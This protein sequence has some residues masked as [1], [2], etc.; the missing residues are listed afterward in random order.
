MNKNQI[1]DMIESNEFQTIYQPIVNIQ[2]NHVFGYE[3]LTRVHNVPIGDF[4]KECEKN[5]LTSQFELR[6]L[7]NGIE[8][9][10]WRESTRLFLNISYDT[11]I[12]H[13]QE[14]EELLK[15]SGEITFEFLETSVIDECQL[16][17]LHVKMTSLKR[18]FGTQFAIDDYGSGYADI[19]RVL[20]HPT[21]FVKTDAE[22]LKDVQNHHGKK[23]VLTNLHH[24]LEKKKKK[25][26]VEGVE[27]KEQFHY[28]V[29]LGITY[30][31]GFYFI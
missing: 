25:M 19:A 31:Q 10:S 30:A 4:I 2:E 28:L 16:L 1:L 21:D 13:Y 27:N 15:E 14:L 7:K 23:L 29:G 11:F 6:T 8:H 26:V 17:D 5:R 24:F 9:F 22:L 18:R 3:S 12:H 20:R